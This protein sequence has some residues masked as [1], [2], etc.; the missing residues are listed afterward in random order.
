[1]TSIL[2]HRGPDSR[3]LYRAPGVSLGV[4]RLSIIDL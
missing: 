2:R 3:Q 1:M 4:R